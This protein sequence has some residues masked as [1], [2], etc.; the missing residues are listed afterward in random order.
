MGSLSRPRL[1]ENKAVLE[2]LAEKPDGSAWNFLSGSASIVDPQ[3]D[4][5]QVDLEQVAPGHYRLSSEASIPGVYLLR[6]GLNDGSQSLGQTTMGLVV[7]Y[8]PEYKSNGL[9]RYTLESLVGAA[10]GRELVTPINSFAHNLTSIPSTHE[11]WLPLLI[12]A[13][14]LFPLEVSLRRL[15]I[16]KSDLADMWE[17]ISSHLPLN[18][19]SKTSSEGVLLGS[20]FAA[21]QRA[22]DR[23][24]RSDA[25]APLTKKSS[26]Q[27]R[28]EKF[29]LSQPK[30]QQDGE[31][32]TEKPSK[33]TLSR[34]REAKKRA[35]R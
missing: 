2:V 26:P 24:E 34:L 35:K 7:P 28:G 13:A 23:Q 3:N 32:D 18:E 25:S 11:I 31:P 30:T 20:L 17:K 21:R 1:E 19:K 29:T 10:G 8:S 27:I 5:R 6:V 9:D 16:Q 33:D 4:T 22:R 14:C 12:L 15:S